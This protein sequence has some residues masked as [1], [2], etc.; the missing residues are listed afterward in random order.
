[1]EQ[2]KPW[3]Q[4]QPQKKLEQPKRKKGERNAVPTNGKIAEPHA[5]RNHSVPAAANVPTT[6]ATKNHLPPAPTVNDKAWTDEDD[7]WQ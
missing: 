2:G 5:G 6:T 1:M 3:E 4:E 7:V